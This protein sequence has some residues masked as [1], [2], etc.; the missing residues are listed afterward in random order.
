M[1]E[2][3]IQGVEFPAM[4]S[5][6]TGKEHDPELIKN[7]GAA[8]INMQAFMQASRTAFKQIEAVQTSLCKKLEKIGEA[9]EANNRAQDEL[10]DSS[11]ERLLRLE[12]GAK[13]K[14]KSVDTLHD[15]SRDHRIEHKDRDSEVARLIQGIRNDFDSRWIAHDARED[16]VREK[17]GQR[18]WEIVRPALQ[19]G[20]PTLFAIYGIKL[21]LGAQ[22]ATQLML[23]GVRP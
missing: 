6:D 12:W 15:H 23:K 7:H 4:M 16:N 11:N 1:E 2:G 17:H 5:I 14:K 21:L 13:E 10:N 22:A 18:V 9:I 3:D 20:L 19:W 8:L